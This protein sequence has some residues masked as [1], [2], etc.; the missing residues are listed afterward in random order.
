MKSIYS[1][2]LDSWGH[3]QFTCPNCDS[4]NIDELGTRK[5]GTWDCIC[6]DCEIEF[7]AE[8]EEEEEE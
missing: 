5:D 4:R 1:K 6:C 3:R 7:E 8:E 2:N